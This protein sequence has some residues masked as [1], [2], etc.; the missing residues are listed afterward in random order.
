LLLVPVRSNGAIASLE[1]YRSGSPFTDSERRAVELAAAQAALV[2][3]GFEIADAR[4]AAVL[5]RPGLELAGDVIAAA[6]DEVDAAGEVARVAATIVGAQAGLI[7]QREGE[8]VRLLGS[9]GT[10]PDD[11][12]DATRTLAAQSLDEA[13]SVR[14]VESDGLPG[15]CAVA[16]TLPL[17]HPPLGV[18]QLLFPDGRGPDAAQL[19]RLTTFGVRAAYALRAN[20]RG[21]TLEL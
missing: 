17:G 13:G 9:Y 14:S 20:A 16:T 10:G 2:L 1:V 19:G 12:L 18:L 8:D 7:W 15:T 21:R 4:A 5:A 6:L 3:R 11:E